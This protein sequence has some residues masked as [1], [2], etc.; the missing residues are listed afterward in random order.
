MIPEPL[1][2]YNKLVSGGKPLSTTGGL[3]L[4]KVKLSNTLQASS[5]VLVAKLCT[6]SA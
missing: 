6:L 4:K 2:R 3:P 1:P 5:I